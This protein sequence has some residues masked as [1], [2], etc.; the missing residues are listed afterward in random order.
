[1]FIQSISLTIKVGINDMDGPAEALVVGMFEAEG[2]L[3][4]RIVGE[5][6]ED[7][8]EDGVPL[9]DQDGCTE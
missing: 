5:A 7:G 6:E 3:L 2:L 8:I 9:G 4:C 1:M